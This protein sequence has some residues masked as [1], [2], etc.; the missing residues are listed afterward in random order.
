MIVRKDAD[1]NPTSFQARYV[2]PLDPSKKVG[3]NFGLEYETEAYRWLDEEH[4]LVTLHN[5]G[6][7][8]WVHPSQRGTDTMPTF[9]EYAKDYFDKYRKPDGSKLSGRA[10][11]CNE[12]V[13][14]RLN[15]TFGPGGPFEHPFGERADDDGGDDHADGS[16]E[17]RDEV[18]LCMVGPEPDDQSE[19]QRQAGGQS[20]ELVE[21]EG[22]R[23]DG[24]RDQ[25]HRQRD[26]DEQGD[27]AGDDDG[28][29]QV[30]REHIESEHD[31]PSFSLF[32]FVSSGK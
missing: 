7:R 22:D 13:L 3:R 4:Y 18:R 20:G 15:K 1:G 30:Y 26:D 16:P 27:E 6:I 28:D 17:A 2:N 19:E 10:N 21:H 25:S 32:Y 23:A 14:R 8:Q 5:K 9:R 24:M 11:R 29:A 31:R 12:I